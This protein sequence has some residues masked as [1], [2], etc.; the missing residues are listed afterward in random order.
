MP[1]Y[2]VVL[3]HYL[4]LHMGH[5]WIQMLSFQKDN[6]A[7]RRYAAIIKKRTNDHHQKERVASIGV[8]A[9]SMKYSMEPLVGM[10]STTRHFCN[11]DE[12]YVCR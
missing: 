4:K 8:V 3:E 9:D 6:P 1:Q 2:V 12:N 7:P 10:T 5:E 11:R